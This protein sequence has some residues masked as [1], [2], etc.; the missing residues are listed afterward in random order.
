MSPPAASP[1]KKMSIKLSSDILE[2]VFDAGALDMISMGNKSTGEKIDIQPINSFRVEFE[3]E[4]LNGSDCKKTLLA[5]NN[6]FLQVKYEGEKYEIDIAWTLNPARHFLQKQ[7]ILHPRHAAPY[8]IRRLDLQIFSLPP[9]PGKLIPF[10]HGQCRT[11][12][13]RKN[14]AGFMFGIQVPVLDEE[15]KN[16]ARMVL[17]YPVNYKFLAGETYQAEILFWGTYLLT[18]KFAPP[19]PRRVKECSQSA[20]PPDYGES[21]AMISMVSSQIRPAT[22]GPVVCF[23]GC[24]N[25]LTRNAYDEK[26]IRFLEE[27]K[28]VLLRA[29]DML[30]DF[31]AH[32]ASTWSGAHHAV[33]KMK[34]TD[35]K[36]P[37]LPVREEFINWACQNGVKP[38][39][40][41]S[42]KGAQPWKKAD[43][44]YLPGYC[45]DRPDWQGNH[46][47]IQY[48][49]PVNRPFMEWLTE[50]LVDDMRGHRYAVFAQDEGLPAPRYKLP[51]QAETHDHLPG[52]AA[53]GFFLVRRELFQ[54]LK[55]E[56]PSIILNGERPQMDAGIW[57]A[58]YLDSLYTLSEILDGIGSDSIRKWSRIRHYYH[59]VPPGMDEIP[60]KHFKTE[61]LDYLMLSTL[62]VSKNY[63]FCELPSGWS[64]TSLQRV[65]RWLDWARKNSRLMHDCVFLPDW[66][67]EGQCDG[68]VRAVGGNGY[69]FFFNANEK[70]SEANLPLD[71]SAGLISG[72]SYRVS[73]E[74]P[75]T[76][77]NFFPTGSKQ[78]FRKN[79]K[80]QLPPHAC[81][82]LKIAGEF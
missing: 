49:C 33:K 23:N 70:T 11:Y 66:P 36:I 67:G 51:C 54:K 71:D 1:E 46:E 31:I 8:L 80:F 44:N 45:D 41:I 19:V 43:S 56:F 30:G 57:D 25:N 21:S 69:A 6:N 59:F 22:G 42:F 3:T 27:D 77:A 14:R 65:G 24:Q 60:V 76:N 58:L 40:Y 55:K 13:L 62:A 73:P 81:I 63:M 47:Q 28:K 50:V 72:K 53:Y 29:K 75:T 18:G 34:S 15:Q 20:L 10:Q 37:G 74:Y 61:N 64:R 35:R 4:T 7:T 52:D 2:V 38:G 32:A 9:D 12:F 39:I 26:N 48:T 78:V 82:L 5:S 16:P 17:G 68:Y 79:L